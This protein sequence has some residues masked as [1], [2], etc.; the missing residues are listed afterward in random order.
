V[1][2]EREEKALSAELVGY[3]QWVNT[4]V[5]TALDFEVRA[6]RGKENKTFV[7]RRQIPGR[8]H[9]IPLLSAHFCGVEPLE[10]FF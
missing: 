4:Y 6:R 8:V 1:V 3:F 5:S 9:S 7:A 10:K 2:D